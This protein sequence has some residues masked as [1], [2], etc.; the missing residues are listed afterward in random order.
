MTS[1]FGYSVMRRKSACRL[2]MPKRSPTKRS[3]SGSRSQIPFTSTLGIA[4]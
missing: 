3:F 1:I 2:A 4:R